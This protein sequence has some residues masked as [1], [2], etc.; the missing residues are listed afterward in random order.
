MRVDTPSPV[1][2][3]SVRFSSKSACAERGSFL[4]Y[5][6]TRAQEKGAFGK[7][8]VILAH[9]MGAT[10]QNYNKNSKSSRL[11]IRKIFANVDQKFSSCDKNRYHLKGHGRNLESERLKAQ[12]G[13][14]LCVVRQG[15]VVVDFVIFLRCTC[16]CMCSL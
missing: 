7:R 2:L 3:C 4:A 9:R 1:G 15:F 11:R 12:G 13:H 14:C 16:L 5:A 10:G 8:W 6:S